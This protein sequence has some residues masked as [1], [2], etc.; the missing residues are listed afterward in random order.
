MTTDSQTKDGRMRVVAVG[1][2]VLVAGLACVACGQQQDFSGSGE[3]A[4]SKEAAKTPPPP[5]PS[6]GT[7]QSHPG[8]PLA[9]QGREPGH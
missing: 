6:G 8:L 9:G 5:A 2:L 3:L 7:I 1:L 4:K